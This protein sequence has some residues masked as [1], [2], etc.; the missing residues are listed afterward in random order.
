MIVNGREYTLWGQFVEGKERFI[1][2]ILEDLDDHM[3]RHAGSDGAKT[4]ITDICLEPNGPTS[5]YFYVK[6]KSFTCGFDVKYGGIVAG[7]DGWLTFNGYLGHTW[8]IKMPATQ[9]TPE[10]QST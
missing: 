10:T 8:R 5:A 9:T 6:G 1:G 2:G 4:E 7:E 3:V